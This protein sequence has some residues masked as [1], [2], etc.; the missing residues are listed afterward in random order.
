MSPAC[1][2]SE[3]ATLLQKV[4]RETKPALVPE[5]DVDALRS[6]AT[7]SGFRNVYAA[8][9]NTYLAKV[10]EGGRLYAIPGSRQRT[11][12]QSAAY[13]VTYYR[14]RYGERWKR[15][16]ASRK[17]SY[18]QVDAAKGGG[19]VVVVWIRGKRQVWL[20]ARGTDPFIFPKRKQAIGFARD[21]L[22]SLDARAVWRGA[23]P[24]A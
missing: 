11:P 8:G 21:Y 4:A 12:H 15:A 22:R 5:A 24:V 13:V 2:S 20:G 17:R 16:L 18:W 10:K 6:H 19:W 7:A 14:L 1:I 23:E 9:G 3:L